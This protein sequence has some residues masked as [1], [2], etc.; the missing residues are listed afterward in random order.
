MSYTLS[1]STLTAT[2]EKTSLNQTVTVVPGAFDSAV[3]S[4]S[5]IKGDN[6]LGNIVV[7]SLTSS[8]FK[9]TGQYY[10]NWSK[11]I[12]YEGSTQTGETW[13]NT[14]VT[15]SKWSEIGANL[16]FVQSYTAATSPSTKT[17]K[18]YVVVNGTVA[19]LTLTQVINNDYT[20]GAQTLVEFVSKGKV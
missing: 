16:N 7:T 18:Y 20:P 13:A 5:V 2:K 19:N 17:A 8:S 15:A 3:T 12:V 10:D 4:I 6:T 9:I 1:P 14:L 11:T